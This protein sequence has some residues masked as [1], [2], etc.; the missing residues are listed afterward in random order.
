MEQ[1]AT[2]RS[3][4]QRRQSEPDRGSELAST[5]WKLEAGILGGCLVLAGICCVLFP[6]EHDTGALR[7]LG[8]L[9]SLLLGCISFA[10]AATARFHADRSYRE[11]RND[12][13]VA[14]A[15]YV[16]ARTALWTVLLVV[17]L[18]FLM[19]IV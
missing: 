10:M 15:V 14:M 19:Q 5:G 11:F 7:V 1:R 6:L 2:N 8:I 4:A 3:D 18:F 13:S 9:A 12:S 16:G 17:V